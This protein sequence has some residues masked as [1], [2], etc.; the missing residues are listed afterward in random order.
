MSL[1]TSTNLVV[2]ITHRCLSPE[3]NLLCGTLIICLVVMVFLIIVVGGGCVTYDTFLYLS[4]FIEKPSFIF[5]F[6]T[7]LALS[8]FAVESFF[9]QH[10]SWYAG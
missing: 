2:V 1:K 3:C 10:Q 8:W 7:H 5:I 9:L 6:F 4:D